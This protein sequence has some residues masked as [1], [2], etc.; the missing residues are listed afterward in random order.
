MQK[1]WVTHYCYVN[2]PWSCLPSMIPSFLASPCFSCWVIVAC[3]RRLRCTSSSSSSSSPSR[4]SASACVLTALVPRLPPPRLARHIRWVG[5]L[6]PHRPP[7]CAIRSILHPVAGARAPLRRSS[8]SRNGSSSRRSGPASEGTSLH[9]RQPKSEFE[10]SR[11]RC[12][13]GRR[14]GYEE[15]KRRDGQSSEV[16]FDTWRRLCGRRAL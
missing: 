4:L 10:C 5:R 13:K 2:D 11:G 8:N 6:S 3:S 9:L 7:N 15:V 14:K 16:L 12:P 1:S